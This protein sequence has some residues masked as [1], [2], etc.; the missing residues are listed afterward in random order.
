MMRYS[1]K[2]CKT[3]RTVFD[4]RRSSITEILQEPALPYHD[5]SHARYRL[6]K[7]EEM[8]SN[9]QP[10]VSID[11]EQEL[12]L[13]VCALTLDCGRNGP[14]GFRHPESA[15]EE[16]VE[17]NMKKLF[18]HCIPKGS[19]RSIV[20]HA[21]TYVTRWN[22][23]VDGTVRP[24]VATSKT[25]KL[26]CLADAYCISKGWDVFLDALLRLSE[27]CPRRPVT[28]IDDF[29]DDGERFLDLFVRRQIENM[30]DFFE[31]EYYHVLRSNYR[32]IHAMLKRLRE[33]GPE[34][35]S[36][37]ERLESI[38]QDVNGVLV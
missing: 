32:D 10:H 27:E 22:D 35:N 14:L 17:S 12:L 7:A 25:K 29:I 37:R 31:R 28:D 3:M 26:L 6:E 11:S 15:P 30:E 38:T 21:V 24:H 9:L 34:R 2:R 16:R 20:D 5:G 23:Y 4:E 19:T 8:L 18:G 13:R 36:A 1:S 33:N